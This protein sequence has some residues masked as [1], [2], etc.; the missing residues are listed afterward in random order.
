GEYDE[1]NP[2]NKAVYKLDPGEKETPLALH[3]YVEIDTE[4]L[5]DLVVERLLEHVHTLYQEHTQLTR[6]NDTAR[7][8]REERQ[9]RLT[10]VIKSISDIEAAQKNLTQKLGSA[11][12]RM[13][14]LLEG[15]I[16]R[17]EEDRLKLLE[18]KSK[19]EQE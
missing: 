3:S 18:A 1:D 11:N 13:Y 4:E 7:I 19:L 5:D 12:E 2:T 9:I 8:V 6:Y 10:Q 15:E 16:N 14:E 17:L